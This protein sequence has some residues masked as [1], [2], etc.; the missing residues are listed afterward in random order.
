MEVLSVVTE[1]ILVADNFNFKLTS[2]PAST[3]SVPNGRCTVKVGLELGLTNGLQNNI[4][5][6]ITKQ[7]KQ[8][9][10]AFTRKSDAL[11]MAVCTFDMQAQNT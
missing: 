9:R 8:D 10:A 2:S 4:A 7:V 11:V 6:H 3:V 1:K 5:A